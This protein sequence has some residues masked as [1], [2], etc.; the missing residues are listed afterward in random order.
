MSENV[1]ALVETAWLA[2]HIHDTDLRVLDASW[3]LPTAHRDPKAEFLDRH[4]PKAHFFDIDVIAD[5]FVELPHM[6]PTSS[7]FEAAVG[8]MGV[9]NNTHV[10]VYDG[11]G[12]FSAPRVWWMFRVF[13]HDK[14]S[15]LNGGL[16]KWEAEG[17]ALESG[18]ATSLFGTFAATL[19]PQMVFSV[20]DMREVVEKQAAQMLDARSAGRFNGTE[21]EP[22]EGL[23]RGHIPGAINL[24]F[25]ALL[26]DAAQ[27]LLPEDQLRTQFAAV[28]LQDQKPVI[29]S[30]GSG[31]TACVL[32]LG[33]HQ[34]GRNDVAVYDG[35]WTEWGGLSDTEVEVS[36]LAQ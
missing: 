18:P 9:T 36:L 29:C 15:V 4:L 30:C 14:V 22:R 5:T 7:E 31:I 20:D 28:G 34:I 1:P 8:A 6:L 21:P 10:V 23:R 25:G 24:P 13:G 3:Y 35:S 16:P 11:A 33:L 19:R 26:D 27:C 17:R 32:A 12:V 2:E